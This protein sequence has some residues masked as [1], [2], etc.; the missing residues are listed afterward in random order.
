MLVA[1]QNDASI[2]LWKKDFDSSLIQSEDKANM[3][4]SSAENT[5]KSK[6]TQ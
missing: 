4:G 2:T 6:L 5:P 1:G 3:N